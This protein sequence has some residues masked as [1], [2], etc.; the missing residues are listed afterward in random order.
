MHGPLVVPLAE[1]LV[2]DSTALLLLVL[3]RRIIT[4][5][6]LGAFQCNDV[7]HDVILVSDI[8]EKC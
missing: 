2:L 3:G 6:A 7:A 8:L 4:A 5:L 1:L